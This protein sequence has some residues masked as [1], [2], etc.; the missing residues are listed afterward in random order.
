MTMENYYYESVRRE[1]NHNA[2]T[3]SFYLE[4]Y[5]PQASLYEQALF[6]RDSVF[7]RPYIRMEVLNLD[8]I[9]MMDSYGFYV[10][11]TSL[12]PDVEEAIEGGRSIWIGKDE[13]TGEKIL[14][15]S[16]PIRQSKKKIGI[17]RY[18]T[19]LALIDKQIAQITFITSAIAFV[20]VMVSLLI[21]LYLSKTIVK[22]I[23]EI[24][25]A[26]ITM[27]EGN[28]QLSIVKRY[29]DEIGQLAETLNFMAKQIL[30][31]E[32]LKKD[33]ISSISHELRTPLTSIKGWSETMITGDLHNKEETKQGLLIIS[34]E[35]DRLSALVEDL[36][37]FSKLQ[38]AQLT[39]S[40]TPMNV[41]ELLQEVFH[42][43]V[44]TAKQKEIAITL[45]Y[46]KDS[47]ILIA[48]YNR[49]KQVLI[50]VIDNA[51]K[52][53][54]QGGDII[55]EVEDKAEYVMIYVRDTGEGISQ[56]DLAHVT[57][58]FYKNSPHTAGSGLGLAICKELM[59]L[60]GGSLLIESI[61]GQGTVVGIR[62]PKHHA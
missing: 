61:L 51:L 4:R 31:N 10:E 42:Q 27:A 33:F 57:E 40:K 29:N 13:M 6:M 52:H 3:A 55:I 24:N 36:L 45:Q 37:D 50:N 47:I 30:K 44:M 46:V 53:T 11:S 12:S 21:S 41:I 7:V 22:P 9:K 56:E 20:I 14:S 5:L 59:E 8:L 54:P 48:D 2:K 25:N 39:L 32:K 18:T 16:A 23:K 60:H 28:F 19:S 15:I 43:Y 49:L 58:K 35:T 17:I 1:L 38:S 34:K 26:A 62:C